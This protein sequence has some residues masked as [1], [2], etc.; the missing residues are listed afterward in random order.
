M[1]SSEVKRGNILHLTEDRRG[2]L[3]D[4]NMSRGMTPIVN[5]ISE[6]GRSLY[7]GKVY[8]DEVVGVELKTD[9]P[10]G[11]PPIVEEIELSNA[12]QKRSKKAKEFEK[13]LL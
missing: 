4:K 5:I 1:K 7:M 10:T 12:Q 8:I 2:I 3:I 6:M 9:K 11:S 13:A